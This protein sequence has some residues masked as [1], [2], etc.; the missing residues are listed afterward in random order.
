MIPK[1]IHACWF[2]DGLMPKEQTEYMLGWKKFHPD[3]EIILW[4]EDSAKKYFDDCRYVKQ[5]LNDKKYAFLSDYVRLKVLYE[6][7]GV[8][9]D[10]DVELKKNFDCFLDCSLFGGFIFDSSVGTAVMGA[11]KGNEEVLRWLNYLLAEFEKTGKF[12]VNNDWMTKYFLD[13]YSDFRL[14]GKRQSLDCGIELY[15]KDYFERYQ[16]NKKSGGGYAEHHC[17][18]SWNDDKVPPLKKFLKKLLPR[19]IV[20]YFGHKKFIKTTPYYSVYLQHK[21]QK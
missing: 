1:I 14:N 2:G 15:P 3:Y 9:L 12:T 7:G 20:S 18:G 11:E 21:K 6:Y 16:I 4:N 17:V 19:A 10:T 5:C 13:N 8:Y